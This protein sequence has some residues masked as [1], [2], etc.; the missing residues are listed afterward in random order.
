MPRSPTTESTLEALSARNTRLCSCFDSQG[1]QKGQETNTLWEKNTLPNAVSLEL[2]EGGSRVSI[3]S[4]A[5]SES[6]RR[7]HKKDE[8][9]EAGVNKGLTRARD[10]G[11]WG[12]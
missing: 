1:S 5:A 4:T 11:K 10:G 12:A 2:K 9:I 3:S 8:S 7:S 6:M